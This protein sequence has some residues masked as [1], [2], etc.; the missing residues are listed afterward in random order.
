MNTEPVQRYIEIKDFLDSYCRE[1]NFT[2]EDYENVEHFILEPARKEVVN[3]LINDI[4]NYYV[5]N[6][7]RLLHIPSTTTVR[8]SVHKIHIRGKAVLSND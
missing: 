8:H 1:Q 7:M 6:V 2:E 4:I 3:L 5:N